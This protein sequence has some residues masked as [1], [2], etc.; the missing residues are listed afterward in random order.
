MDEESAPAV[1]QQEERTMQ[2]HRLESFLRRPDAVMEPTIL[3]TLRDYVIAQGDPRQ[4]VKLLTE[5]YV[6][7]AQ[8]ATLVCKWLQS[9]ENGSYA[10]HSRARFDPEGSSTP[11]SKRART[12]PTASVPPSHSVIQP[13]EAVSSP[14]K[15]REP[16]S[17]AAESDNEAQDISPGL[18][19]KSSLDKANDH[20]GDVHENDDLHE[21]VDLMNSLGKKKEG[22]RRRTFDAPSFLHEVIMDKF[23]PKKFD[24]VFESTR[25]HPVIPIMNELI[26][27]PDGRRLIYQLAQQ[28]QHSLLLSYALA[29]ILK[30]PGRDMEVAA[31]VTSFVG[32][33]DVYH[34]LLAARL[35]QAT[36]ATNER[37]LKKIVREISVGALMDQHVYVHTQQMLLELAS[38][39]SPFSP[40]FYRMF[41]ELE[42]LAPVPARWKLWRALFPSMSENMRKNMVAER[43]GSKVSPHGS[44]GDDDVIPSAT[45]M[46]AAAVAD[47][48][49]VSGVSTHVPISEVM[50]LRQIYFEGSESDSAEGKPTPDNTS[51]TST[52]TG[53]FVTPPVS[54]LRH[55]KLLD[56]LIASLFTPGKNL[57]RHIQ[58]AHIDVLAV[59]V[60]GSDMMA[61]GSAEVA[62]VPLPSQ[63]GVKTAKDAFTN[64]VELSHKAMQDLRLKDEEIQSLRNAAQE[65]SAATGMLRMLRCVLTSKDHWSS[66]YMIHKEPSFLSLLNAVIESQPGWHHRVLSLISDAFTAMGHDATA[67]DA[68]RSLLASAA[69]LACAGGRVEDVMRWAKSW[70]KT[71]EPSS[72]RFLVVKL[73]EGASPPYSP[74]FASSML[75]LAVAGNVRRQ[76]M[77][78]KEWHLRVPILSEFVRGCQE[79][80]FEPALNWEESALLR[81]LKSTLGMVSSD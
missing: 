7:Y 73:L 14:D 39:G 79:I 21:G 3:D 64:A 11:P 53:A 76:K 46:T 62:G 81:D 16:D 35:R 50:K 49:S 34:R 75:Q 72:V 63:P 57:Q 13:L 70:S 56:M 27:D 78:S 67:S 66:S 43:E 61:L 45:A 55:P 10:Q 80:A 24:G 25:R 59:A 22:T 54:L 36:E 48:L 23:D 28:H 77:S 19:S 12:S 71:A 41:Q 65:P 4:A 33:F 18:S 2:L 26:E 40:R 32:P 5:N 31:A 9:V 74:W 6:G 30:Q 44:A 38:K 42:S 68:A 15:R 8:M 52:A 20:I 1:G 29:K 51:G 58:S 47:I 37:A 17:R 69:D 60:A